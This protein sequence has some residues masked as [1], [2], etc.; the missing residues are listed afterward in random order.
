MDTEHKSAARLEQHLE[1]VD[2]GGTVALNSI[3]AV[4]VLHSA[5][6]RIERHIA[7]QSNNRG[8]TR[9]SS[10]NRMFRSWLLRKRPR[11]LM[12]RTRRPLC[13]TMS[14]V[15]RGPSR[16]PNL[17]L[18]V[19]DGEHS[20][21]ENGVADVLGGVR[22]G[23]DLGQ[24]V[25][26][27]V[28]GLL[29][30]LAEV[31]QQAQNGHLRG[32]LWDHGSDTRGCAPTWRKGSVMPPTSCSAEYPVVRFFSISTSEGI[33]CTAVCE[34]HAHETSATYAAEVLQT[35]DIS[36]HHLRNEIDAG[37]KHSVGALAQLQGYQKEMQC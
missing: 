30:T 32:V 11:M 29:V 7:A 15:G 18:D 33:S 1:A 36:A 9:Y 3:R 28:A 34:W 26:H 8:K 35:L 20:L 5:Q 24:D 12:A 17:G 25:V 19:H 31:A 16:A 14:D 22:V 27:G 23:G 6:Q 37:D 10:A 2:N 4:R 21:V 13:C